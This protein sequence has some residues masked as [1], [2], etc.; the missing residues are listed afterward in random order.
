MGVQRR[1]PTEVKDVVKERVQSLYLERGLED[2]ET[3]DILHE[4][5]YYIGKYTLVQLRFELGLKRRQSRKDARTET[6]VILS[7]RG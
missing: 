6:D 2:Y 3:L 7:S 4:E 1:I 5:G